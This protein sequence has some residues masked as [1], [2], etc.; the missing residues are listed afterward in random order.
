MQSDSAL[1]NELAH[2]TQYLRELSGEEG[3]AMKRVLLEIYMDVAAL[4]KQHG[5][6]MMLSGGSCLGAIRH[7]GFIP[8]DDDLDVMMPRRDYEQLIA[9]LQTGALGEKYAYSAPNPETESACVFLKIYRQNSK[10]VDIFNIE[11]PFHKGIYIDVFAIDAVPRNGWA[12]SLKGLI[13]NGLQ[14]CSILTLYANYSNTVIQEYMGMSPQLK[15]RYRLK[16]IAGKI[17]D[18]IPRKKWNWWF[19]QWVSDAAEDKPWG[20]PTGRKYYNGEVFPKDVF[21]P[22]NK[23]IFEGVEVAVPHDYDRYLRNLYHDYMQ[24]PPVEKRERHFI[25][26][27]ELPKDM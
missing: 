21:V 3:A 9:L 14:F 19:D 26:Q 12:R 25:Y 2:R 5:L 13:A 7:Q 17:V 27:F 24:L 18:I 10:N 6:T 1:L 23:A 11:S 20:I 22:T 8:W 16:C 4:C 15:R